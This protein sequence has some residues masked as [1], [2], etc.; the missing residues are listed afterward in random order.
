M[1]EER[2]CCAVNCFCR[3]LPSPLMMWQAR[4]R[5]VESGQERS[6][7]MT[8]RLA[9]FGVPLC[10]HLPF[11]RCPPAEETE[12]VR[13]PHLPLIRAATY[14]EP[15][16]KEPCRHRVAESQVPR[17]HRNPNTLDACE[18]YLSHSSATSTF[19]H[20]LPPLLRLEAYCRHRHQDASQAESRRKT[21]RLQEGA[22]NQRR[23]HP[24][25]NGCSE[26]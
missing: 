14:S 7:N 20:K 11:T 1:P 24:G 9:E 12:S 13:R 18:A 5:T 6:R 25:S 17:S 8:G 4:S 2:L 21:G 26:G 23:D 10:V 19:S 16:Q 22:Q 15:D 3:K